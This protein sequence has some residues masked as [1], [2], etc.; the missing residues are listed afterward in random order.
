[1]PTKRI[2]TAAFTILL[3]STLSC[4]KGGPRLPVEPEFQGRVEGTVITDESALSG[5]TV[6]LS[7]AQARTVQTSSNGAFLFPGLSKGTYLVEI[8]D[9]PEDV[10]FEAISKS[11]ILHQGKAAARVDFTG[12]KKRD[13]AINGSVTMEG[14]GMAGMNISVSGPEFRSATTDSQGGF[15]LDQLKRGVYTLTLSGF[16]PSLHSFPT[17]EQTVDVRSGATFE[18][19]FPGTLVPQPPEAPIGPAAL[20]TGPA[21]VALSWTDA[22]DDET[23]FEI[24]RREEAEGS[25]TQVATPE[26]NAQTF[27]DEGLSPNTSYT[28]RVRACNDIGCSAFSDEAEATTEDVA[29]EAPTEL[30]AGATG[31]STVGLGWTDRSN[32]EARFEVER[33]EETGEDWSQIE[34]TDPNATTFSD[35]GLTPNTTYLYRIR[36]CNAVGC[37]AYSNE[38]GATTDDVAPEAPSGLS[39]SPTGS[40]TV[41]LTWTDGSNNETRFEIER[42]IGAAGDWIQIGGSDPDAT[43]FGDTGLTPNTTYTYRVRACNAVG[44]S[45][46]SNEASAVTHEVAPEAPTDLTPRP[47]DPRR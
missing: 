1:M 42:R 22:S 39:A 17:S 31:S 34:T 29:P 14:A 7:G 5:V 43:V 37:S 16:D 40:T 35:A 46:Y 2:C 30:E 6:R 11:A 24:E 8:E 19:H 13:G 41:S 26:P 3:L 33:K 4:D 47:P 44:C 45:A 36:A 12:A 18:T 10:E 21:T 32:N 38:A 27:G 23:R 28:Y 25:W 20:A 15:A 9:F